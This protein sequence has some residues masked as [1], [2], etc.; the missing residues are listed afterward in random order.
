MSF[1][2]WLVN[3]LIRGISHLLLRV[4]ARELAT[5]SRE[6]PA[7]LVLNH[8]N[9][10]DAPIT[11]VH[12]MPRPVI[13][14]AKVETWDNGLIGGLFTLWEGIPIKRGEVDQEAF[15]RILEAL[16]GGKMVAVTPEGTRTGDG[17]LIQAKPGIALLALRSGAPIYPLAVYGHEHFWQNLK[18]FRRSDFIVRV[19]KPFKLVDHGQALSRDVRQQMVDEIMGQVALLMPEAQRGYYSSQP[20]TTYLEFDI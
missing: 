1:A 18:R 10:L 2:A 20:T 6:G 8:T 7:L 14:V 5:A 3:G 16:K 11:Y 4:N 15:R 13:P 17:C 12:A 9:F 19:G